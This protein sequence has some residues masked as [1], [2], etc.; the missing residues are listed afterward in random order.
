MLKNLMTYGAV[1]TKCRALW[2]MRLRSDDYRRIVSLPNVAQVA[3]FLRSQPRWS[4]ALDGMNL[5]EVTRTQLE[6]ALTRFNVEEYLRLMPYMDKA[7]IELMKYPV[8]VVEISQIMRFLQF[9]RIGKHESYTFNMPHFFDRHSKINYQ[10]LSHASNYDELLDAVSKT[11]FVHILQR[12]RPEGGGFPEFS[13]VEIALRGHY[14]RS[15]Y[16]NIKKTRTGNDRTR[17]LDNV[18]M[19]ADLHN[20]VVIMRLRSFYAA[21]DSAK[22]D[23]ASSQSKDVAQ[24]ETLVYKY[25]LPI[26]HRLK[27]DFIRSMYLAPTNDELMKLLRSSF[28]GKFFAADEPYAEK[29]SQNIRYEFYRSGIHESLPTVMTMLSYMNLAELELNNLIQAIE[30]V[31]F[32][33]PPEEAAKFFTGRD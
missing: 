2:G 20:I 4:G 18:G 27:A 22:K 23:E 33:V 11:D 7:D 5:Q 16:D 15:L 3:N 10:A 9:A 28:Y 30:C 1:A 25:L 8:L 13:T 24:H 12:L 14:L 29:Y 17:L 6:T 19:Q 32:K 31:K 21:G 26:N